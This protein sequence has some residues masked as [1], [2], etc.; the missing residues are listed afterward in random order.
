[1]GVPL[2]GVPPHGCASYGYALSWVC[3]LM[4]VPLTGVS[5]TGVP[6]MGMPSHGCAFS[7][8]CLSWVCLLMGVPLMGVPLM[9]VPSH[10]RA[11][12][13]LVCHGCAY[14]R[15]PNPI[16]ADTGIAVERVKGLCEIR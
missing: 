14:H 12:H 11:S 6:L 7:W 1:M 10:G 13:G 2:M 8:V 3:L 16:V 9:G 4:G 15:R 5:F